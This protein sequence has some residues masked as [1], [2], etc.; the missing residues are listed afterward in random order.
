MKDAGH[1]TVGS[2]RMGARNALI[3]AQVAIS[4]V[5]LVGAGLLVRSFIKLQQV[6]ARF[7]HRPRADR[8][9]RR[10]TS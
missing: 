2:R 7:P 5:L 8:A 1:R 10:S 9:G 6:D 4:F 3:V